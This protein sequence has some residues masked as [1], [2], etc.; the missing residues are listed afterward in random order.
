MLISGP[1][2]VNVIQPAVSDLSI[3][4]QEIV[5]VCIKV[6]FLHLFLQVEGCDPH[7][8]LTGERGCF[9]TCTQT[10]TRIPC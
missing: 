3:P 6:A 2:P 8:S 7:T 1:H 9:L 10:D 5:A 4:V